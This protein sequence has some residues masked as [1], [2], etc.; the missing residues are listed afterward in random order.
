M[1]YKARWLFWSFV[2]SLITSLFGFTVEKS[3]C[4]SFKTRHRICKRC[5]RGQKAKQ[6]LH[7][8]L[9]P[10][11]FG[12]L[13]LSLIALVPMFVFGAYLGWEARPVG[14]LA[15]IA[16]AIVLVAAFFGIIDVCS[17]IPNWIVPRRLR[18]IGRK[19]FVMVKIERAG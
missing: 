7:S 17:R 11:L 2:V 10:V 1:V 3:L 14:L 4:I 12:L 13:I 6:A 5:Y 18:P 9:Q 16:G 19:P 15:F 8:L